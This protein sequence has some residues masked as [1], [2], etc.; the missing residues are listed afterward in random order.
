MVRND[1]RFMHDFLRDKVHSCVF[2]GL[3]KER[4]AKSSTISLS[5]QLNLDILTTPYDLTYA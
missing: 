3:T 5:H 1:E 2:K 4:S